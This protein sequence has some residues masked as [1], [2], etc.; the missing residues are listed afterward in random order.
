MLLHSGL[1]FV[2][3]RLQLL[4]IRDVGRNGVEGSQRNSDSGVGALRRCQRPRGVVF[5][6]IGVCTDLSHVDGV[7][8]NELIEIAETAQPRAIGIEVLFQNVCE[9][10]FERT[11]HSSLFV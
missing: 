3:V 2:V 11:W 1:A 4:H 10:L 5:H 7:S 9:D 6:N 8:T